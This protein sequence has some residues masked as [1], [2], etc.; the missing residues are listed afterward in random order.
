MSEPVLDPSLTKDEK[1][2][3]MLCHLTGLAGL[4]VPLGNVIA[5]LVL[6]LIKKDTMP[7]VDDQGKESVNF[8]ISVTLYLLLCIP[9]LFVLIGIPLMILIGVGA[10]I[11]AILATIKANEGIAYRYPLTIRFIR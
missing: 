2:Y 3:A 11:F 4:I 10:V 9:L 6:W 7:F 5:P 8:Q 1:T